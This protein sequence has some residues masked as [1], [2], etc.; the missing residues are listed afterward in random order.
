MGFAQKIPDGSKLFKEK[1]LSLSSWCPSEHLE[2]PASG[3]DN[4]NYYEINVN[5]VD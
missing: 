4:P 5:V 2:Q 3:V 1:H